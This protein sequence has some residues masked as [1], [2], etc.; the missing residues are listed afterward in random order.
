MPEISSDSRGQTREIQQS[1]YN[2]DLILSAR[3]DHQGGCL[4]SYVHVSTLLL[5]TVH[6]SLV[7]YY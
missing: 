3:N 1:L 7:L 4:R 5:S 6:S 2:V